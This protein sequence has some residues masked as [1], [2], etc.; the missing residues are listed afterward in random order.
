MYTLKLT[1][2]L[3]LTF[4]CSFLQATQEPLAIPTFA[5]TYAQ[6]KD[7]SNN[8]V[9][10]ISQYDQARVIF[11]GSEAYSL[12]GDGQFQQYLKEWA[13]DF[14]SHMPITIRRS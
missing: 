3:I 12:N 13:M 7:P 10:Y 1:F 4:L 9:S 2:V 8:F 5:S 11:I 6:W 14:Y